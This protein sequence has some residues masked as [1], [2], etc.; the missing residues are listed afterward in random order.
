MN[1]LGFLSNLDWSSVSQSLSEIIADPA[2]NLT[3][4]VLLVGI[5]SV[6]LLIPIILVL[7]F[8]TRADED[9]DDM[10]DD[11]GFSDSDEESSESESEAEVATTVSESEESHAD[12]M[13]TQPRRRITLPPAL[14]KTLLVAAGIAVPLLVVGSLAGGYVLSA[15][16]GYCTSCHVEQAPVVAQ[17]ASSTAETVT[18]PVHEGVR[19]TSCHEESQAWG[20]IGNSFSR[21]RHL[22]AFALGKRSSGGGQVPS[23]RCVNCHERAM[24]LIT[25]D[26][27]RGLLMSH[28]EP[29]AAGVACRDCHADSGHSTAA[30]GPRMSICLTCHD[31]EK[32]SSDCKTCHTKE[33]ALATNER[34][35]FAANARVTRQDCTGCHDL[36][37]CD[38]CHG[39]RLPHD[40]TFLK[41]GHSRIAA[42]DGKK[43][44]WRCH[45]LADC[46]KCHEVATGRVWGHAQNWKEQHKV[47]PDGVL[48]GCGC[49]GRSPYVQRKQD[50]CLQCH[51]PGIRNR[52]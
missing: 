12:E 5:A 27:S 18:V 33:P 15:Q 19:C 39:L 48:A 3:A 13:A 8:L 32:V 37:K 38:A 22:V 6:L 21:A 1:P 4:A 2:S 31:G 34:R 28:K 26:E 29:L 49:H 51:P 16:N 47:I 30:G 17:P 46:S 45:V 11:E 35:S 14:R 41:Y 44:C 23:S 25:Q 9:A 52:K 36:K 42:F 40:Q 50:Y 20:F 24:S 43:L 7:F 10:S